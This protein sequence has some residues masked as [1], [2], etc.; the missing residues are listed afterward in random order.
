LRRNRGRDT[1][2]HATAQQDYGSIF[3]AFLTHFIVET[4]PSRAWILMRLA[5]QCQRGQTPRTSAPQ[6]YL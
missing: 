6:M 2:V 1:A 5:R 4:G 3:V